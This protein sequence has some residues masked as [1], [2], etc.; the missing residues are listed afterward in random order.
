MISFKNNHQPYIPGFSFLEV[1]IALAIVS[2]VFTPIFIAE[3]SILRTT[4]RSSWLID[5]VMQAHSFFFDA[6][7]ASAPDTQQIT[8]EKRVQRPATI[9]KYTVHKVPDNSVLRTF[10][11]MYIEQVTFEWTPELADTRNRTQ[12]NRDRIGTYIY[13]PAS[14]KA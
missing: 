2:L 5:R 10:K 9:L 1:I 8:V 14:T 12:L 7:R 13:K 4:F 3:S 11:D 6:Q